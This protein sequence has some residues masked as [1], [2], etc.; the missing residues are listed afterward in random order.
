MVF[1][2]LREGGALPS[3]HVSSERARLHVEEQENILEMVQH[4]PTTSTT[5]LGVSRTRVWRT[6][7]D[8][9]LRLFHPQLVQNV[10]P[11]AVPCF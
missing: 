3:A 7:H 9:D 2:T 11:G 6:L 5:R 8:D 4:S 1:G 10:H